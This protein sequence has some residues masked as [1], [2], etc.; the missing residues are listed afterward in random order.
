[1]RYWHGL[2]VPMSWESFLKNKEKVLGYR[3]MRR[4]SVE[5]MEKG[6]QILIYCGGAA[7]WVGICEVTGKA[8]VDKRSKCHGS[9]D[10]PVRI[11]IKILRVPG[12]G[13]RTVAC[14]LPVE[15][16]I[17]RDQLI[18]MFEGVG[19]EEPG[20]ERWRGWIRGSPIEYSDRAAGPIPTDGEIVAEAIKEAARRRKERD[21]EDLPKRIL[22][23]EYG[24]PARLERQKEREEAEYKKPRRTKQG[25]AQLTARER[26]K[27]LAAGRRT[28]GKKPPAG[29]V[30]KGVAWAQKQKARRTT[31]FGL[32]LDE[33]IGLKVSNNGKIKVTS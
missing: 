8:Y 12:N 7:R 14:A 10:F 24:H 28:Y 32:L 4:P 30:E 17:P 13:K 9:M 5:R 20:K 19:K 31:N 18:G 22:N 33:E 11:P 2:M 25:R 27:V 15:I 3:M 23:W 16:G 29:F 6:D 26:M 1:M 21:P